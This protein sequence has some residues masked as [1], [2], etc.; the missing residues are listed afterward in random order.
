MHVSLITLGVEDVD[1]S[2][3]FY[4]AMSWERSDDSV[5]G[6]VAFL[7]GGANV[8][9]LFG[10]DALSEDA[11]GTTLAPPPAAVALATNV[12][13]PDVVEAVLAAAERAGGRIVKPGQEVSWGGYSGYYAD[14]DGHLWEVAHNPAWD[15]LDGGRVLLSDDPEHDGEPRDPRAALREFR[16]RVDAEGPWDTAEVADRVTAL[17]EPVMERVAEALAGASKDQIIATMTLL[18]ERAF[19]A[20]PVSRESLVRSAASSLVSSLLTDPTGEGRVD[21]GR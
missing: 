3:R 17:V 16:E 4:E 21:A 7:R 14:P 11:A 6:Q 13:S 2:T 8:L 18:D 12:S 19:V 10:R 15:L 1:R 9:G 20:P 5:P